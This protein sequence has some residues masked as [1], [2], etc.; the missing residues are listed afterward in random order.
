MSYDECEHLSALTRP[1]AAKRIQKLRVASA[2]AY[3][4]GL[5]LAFLLGLAM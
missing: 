4:I 1:R 5:I 3:A 2:A